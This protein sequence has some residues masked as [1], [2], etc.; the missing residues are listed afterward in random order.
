MVEKSCIVLQNP[1][2]IINT[3]LAEIQMLKI[4]LMST[5]KEIKNMFLEAGGKEI[6]ITQQRKLTWI[7]YYIYPEANFVGNELG[8]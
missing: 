1:Y 5:Q 8:I 7:E 6:L 4:I 2:I 3:I